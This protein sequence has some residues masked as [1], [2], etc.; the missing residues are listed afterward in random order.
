MIFPK[1][2]RLFFVFVLGG[3]CAPFGALADDQEKSDA[4]S[5]DLLR[6]YQFSA[7][8]EDY[9]DWGHWGSKR[10]K[11]SDWTSHSNRLI[12]VYSFG[13]SLDQY[14]GKNSVYRD[15]TALQA[16]YGRLPRQTLNP[17]A[18]YMDQTDIYRLQK[19][20]VAAGKK[21]IVLLVFDGMDWPTTRA[22]AIYRTGRISYVGGRGS[23]LHFLGYRG[24]STEYGFM[25]TSP[26]N[27]GTEFDTNAQRVKNP[28]GEKRGG[29]SWAIGG[30]TPWA[31]VQDDSY[32]LGK[33][34]NLPHVVT[35]SAASATSMCS[36]IKT[37]NGAINVDSE[38]N[39]VEPIARQ[40]Q[41][42]GFSIG[43]VTSVPISHATPA[44]AY[45]NNVTRNDYQDL[46]RDLLGIR[47]I[48]HRNQA[49][50]GADVLLG[51]GWGEEKQ[52]DENQGENFVPGNKYLT[53][54]D[55]AAI[56]VK[57]GGL[58]QIAQRSTGRIGTE[59]LAEATDTAIAEKT[60]LFGFFGV[61]EG[62][63]PYQTADGGYNPTR[64]AN[65]AEKYAAEDIS[66]NVTL[67][68]MTDSALRFLERNEKGFWL[69]VEAGDVDWAN[70]DNNLDNAIGAVFSGD[71]AFRVVTE[72]VDK[73]DA[74]DDTAVILT[75]DHGHYFVL[76]D[77]QILLDRRR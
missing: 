14:D 48:A 37:Y 11:F 75:A 2:S 59:V 70:H 47:S 77:A 71:D 3:V 16:I 49:L 46:T 40:L 76:T 17:N 18:S 19:D 50:S 43:I 67:A 1:A 56:D 10:L 27:S 61:S 35:D 25:V 6:S 38:G 74:W 33:R 22:A 64:G 4:D 41:R 8:A 65:K 26:H 68:D 32:L 69:M 45:A 15:E 58:Y 36:G 7:I 9:A 39:Q 13:L 44:S 24:T 62:H 52:E 34:R 60:R 55:L 30:S 63:L 20:A 73:N 21:N 42:D 29:Y 53:E 31:K 12:P 66:E 5:R 23:G 72:W 57:N 28:G 54:S 51:A